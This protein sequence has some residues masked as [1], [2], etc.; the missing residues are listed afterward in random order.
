MAKQKPTPRTTPSRKK[1]Q[2]KPI[3]KGLDNL[4]TIEGIGPKIALLL[5][6]EGIDS[7]S[8]LARAAKKRL[9]NILEKAGP[10]Y[11]AHDP[12]TWQQQ[13][14]LASK[15]K[16]DELKTL[17]KK[18]IGGRN[19]KPLEELPQI[20]AAQQSAAVVFSA[21]GG[22]AYEPGKP[23]VIERILTPDEVSQEYAARKPELDK[24]FAKAER[25]A[26]ALWI[27]LKELPEFEDHITGIAV[28]YRTKF[29]Q[30]LS[31][32]RVVVAVNVARK[33]PANELKKRGYPCIKTLCQ[34]LPAEIVVE[35]KILEG[36]FGF[37]VGNEDFFLRGNRS[38]SQALA[39]TSVVT[40]GVPIHRPADS[41]SNFG[42]L[43]LV[44]VAA[45]RASFGL[46]AQHV[47]GTDSTVQQI[48]DQG[49]DRRIGT[50]SDVKISP[51]D[52]DTG[53][54]IES[55]DAAAIKLVSDPTVLL[56]NDGEWARE[57]SHAFNATPPS[58]NPFPI[59]FSNRRIDSS[60]QSRIVVKFGNG[61]GVVTFG[62]IDSPTQSTN[63]FGKQFVR[64]FTIKPYPN[65]NGPFSRPGDS[66]SIVATQATKV[67]GNDEVAIII[68]G[69]LFA[70][71]FDSTL[72]IA[73][74]MDA[75]VKGLTLEQTLVGSKFANEWT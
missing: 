54:V 61:S 31:P 42:T 2:A 39:F 13:S 44:S 70:G 60:D 11:R 55:I 8:K 34:S 15:G 36:R 58:S 43:G 71:L 24:D 51:F 23:Y 49:N 22:G 29:G 41:L 57:I 30:V 38:P 62:K 20:V 9:L 40:G 47:V 52:V 67:N 6:D 28:R 68:I 50:V 32:L 75:V 4:Q 45:G 5:Q 19:R 35:T 7:F 74:N 10:R 37:L 69:I 3:S 64:N 21:I 63:I 56:P 33:L 14:A 66:G 16:W 53:T 72:G 25:C 17:Q 12:A 48:N 27:R 46:T 73:C 1:N 26:D 18:L 59:Y 65:S